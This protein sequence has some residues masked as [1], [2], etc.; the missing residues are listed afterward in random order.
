MIQTIS[1]GE[2][3][4]LIKSGEVDVVDVREPREW[5][6]GHV[7]KARLVPLDQLRA[8]PQRALPRDR[9]VFVCA[10]G[11]RS[12]TAAKLAER[13]GFNQLYNLDGGTTGWVKAGLPLEHS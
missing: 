4:A 13:L 5:S 8:D 10:K 7:P 2:A 1:P 9:V 12:L 6:F 3:D 11:V